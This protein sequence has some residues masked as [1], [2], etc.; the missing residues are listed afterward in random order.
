[1][2]SKVVTENSPTGLLFRV[3]RRRTGIFLRQIIGACIAG[4][5]VFLVAHR[6]LPLSAA[7]AFSGLVAGAEVLSIGRGRVAVLKVTNLEL[8]SEAHIEG[9]F[10]S[11]RSICRADIRGLEYQEDT[12]GPETASHPGGLYADVRHGSVCLLPNI[13]ES[14]TAFIIE[15]IWEHFPDFR[16]QCAEQSPFEHFTQLHLDQASSPSP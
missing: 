3:E 16:K 13:D 15:S 14:Q 4:V 11:R 1:M 5:V 10:R 9:W 7:L 8:A 6:Y 12:T 2:S